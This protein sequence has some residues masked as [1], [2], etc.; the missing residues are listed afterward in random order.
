MT[1]IKH[2]LIGGLCPISVKYANAFCYL[3]GELSA[4]ESNAILLFDSWN[5]KISVKSLTQ[6]LSNCY[7]L[8]YWG[9]DKITVLFADIFI[10]IFFNE[11]YVRIW[12]KIYHKPSMVIK[13][14]SKLCT[15]YCG[16]DFDVSTTVSSHLEWNIK[17]RYSFEQTCNQ[18]SWDKCHHNIYI[19]NI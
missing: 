13:M 19:Y 14:K 18:I 9:R 16:L 12:T 1:Y 2:N 7:I 10:C 3:L 6:M 11:I 5:C 8:T 17:S 15:P 4:L